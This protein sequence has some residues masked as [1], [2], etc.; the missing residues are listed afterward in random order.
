MPHYLRA[1]AYIV[2]ERRGYALCNDAQIASADA[3]AL[4]DK[5]Q[6]DAAKHD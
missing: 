3:A 5:E 6:R 1:A 2:T 4:I